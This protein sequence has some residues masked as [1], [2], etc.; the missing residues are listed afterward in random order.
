MTIVPYTMYL[1][2]IKGIPIG[3]AGILCILEP[4]VASVVGVIVFHDPMNK[5]GLLGILVVIGSLFLVE[6]EKIEAK[7]K[8]INE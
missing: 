3:I 5:W 1:K 8:N 7:E 4:V 6:S 2:G